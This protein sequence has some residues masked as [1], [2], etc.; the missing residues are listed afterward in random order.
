[1]R[2][3]KRIC[4]F[5]LALTIAFLSVGYEPPKANAVVTEVIGTSALATSALASYMTA[6]GVPLSVISGGAAAASAGTASLISGYAAATGG[7]VEV[8]T[9]SIAAGATIGTGGV[10]IL[11]AAAALVLAGIVAWAIDAYRLG[12][13]DGIQEPASLLVGDYVFSSFDSAVAAAQRGFVYPK[14][15]TVQFGNY[16]AYAG[17]AKG[18]T[19][20][21]ENSLSLLDSDDWI[22]GCQASTVSMSPFFNFYAD[23]AYFGFLYYDSDFNYASPHAAVTN[24]WDI[25]RLPED[26]ANALSALVDTSGKV[27]LSLNPDYAPKSEL[28]P[29]TQVVLNPNLAPDFY[30]DAEPT[31]EALSEAIFEKL[32]NGDFSPQYTEQPVADPDPD[33]DTGGGDNPDD[34][35]DEEPDTGVDL[36]GVLG[37]LEAIWNAIKS[38]VEA[39]GDKLMQ[40]FVPSEEY[41]E[42]LPEALTDAFAERT[43]F[44]TYPMSL[45]FG[46]VDLIATPAGDFILEWDDVYEPFSHGKLISAG[47]FNVTQYVNS[48][49]ALSNVYSLWKTV[50]SGYLIFMFFDLC[51]KKYNAIV[52]DRLG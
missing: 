15:T 2:V 7:T 18:C 20:G 26:L 52:R 23:G 44:L 29:D 47:Q 34:G 16:V 4:A 30:P 39:I 35:T 38:L 49:Q 17:Y 36:S 22:V 25:N 13:A 6:T 28:A 5:A 33:P 43:G 37:W 51:Y 12:D 3:A 9:T 41:M 19:Y 21:F 24:Q 10:I 32:A 46:F 1:M 27:S 42:A 31:P 40:L 45:L 8:I 11:S 48:N 50:V 14:N